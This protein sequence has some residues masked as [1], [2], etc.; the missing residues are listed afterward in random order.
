VSNRLIILE[1]GGEVR[2]G[3]EHT[4]QLVP[5]FAPPFA[6]TSPLSDQDRE[7]L[8]WY[9]EDY[10]QTPYAV[11]E[12][13]GSRIQARLKDWGEG[14]FKALFD[15]NQP[16]HDRYVQA[17]AGGA[18]ELVL[19]SRNGAFLTLPWELLKDPERA[20]P[21]VVTLSSCDRT[22]GAAVEASAP[23]AS[24]DVLRVLM[25]IARPDGLKDVGYQMIARP[26]LERLEAVRGRVDLDVLRPPTFEALKQRLR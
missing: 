23:A 24:D 6:F 5:E 14:L 16:A 12:E 26:L 2:V 19:S 13:H 15:G 10:L 9:L 1:D 11:Y 7:D 17:R 3:L 18:T 25:V 22:F 8:R 21:L 4:G 20:D